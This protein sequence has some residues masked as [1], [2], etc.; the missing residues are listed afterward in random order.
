VRS[1]RVVVPVR[2]WH[3][4]VRMRVV[5]VTVALVRV[6]VI[7]VG[8]RV[9]FVRRLCVGLGLGRWLSRLPGSVPLAGRFGLGLDGRRFAVALS[10]AGNRQRQAK[11]YRDSHVNGPFASCV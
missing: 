10:A 1:V 4:R 7:A 6:R 9:L 5:V 2:P 8:V 3:V 11:C